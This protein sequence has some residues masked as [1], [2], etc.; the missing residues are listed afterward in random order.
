MWTISG[1]AS[2]VSPQILRPVDILYDF[3]GPRL[4][5]S[6][7]SD[8]EPNLVYWCDE[9]NDVV[10]Y[11]VV[12]TTEARIAALVH[13]KLTV[14]AA[15]DQPRARLVDVLAD[16][17]IRNSLSIDITA[18]P[19]DVLPTPGTLLTSALEQTAFDLEGRIRALDTDE[20]TFDLREIASTTSAQRFRFTSDLLAT[21]F[22]CLRESSRVRVQGRYLPPGDLPRV[23]SLS[24]L[25]TTTNAN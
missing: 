23:I 22:D 14:L 16:G 7:D 21:V 6:R 4:F 2:P 12:P 1:K 11:L 5:V 25:P 17:S 13:G 20:Q 19:R 9:D 3:D 10:R 8:G 24:R 15:L 18:L